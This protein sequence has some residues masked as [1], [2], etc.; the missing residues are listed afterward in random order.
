MLPKCLNPEMEFVLLKE[1]A[2]ANAEK[3]WP[4]LA[5]ELEQHLR[6]CERCRSVFPE[7]VER[8]A[9]WDQPGEKPGP[10]Q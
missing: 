5:P 1:V 6:E 4:K 3:R 7:W 10:A 9:T 2:F 8:L